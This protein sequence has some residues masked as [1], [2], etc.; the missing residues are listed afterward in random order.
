[1]KIIGELGSGK[2]IE[3]RFLDSLLV[4]QNIIEGRSTILDFV[5][6]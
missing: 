3:F 2:S 6:N 1:M 4:V 5:I